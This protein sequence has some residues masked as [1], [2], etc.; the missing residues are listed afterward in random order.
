[1][2]HRIAL[3]RVADPWRDPSSGW[4]QAWT[5]A[6]PARDVTTTYFASDP[7]EL[8][9]SVCAV[10]RRSESSR[11]ILLM[12]RSDNGHWGLPGGYVERGESVLAAAAREVREETGWCVE[13][14]RL[15]GV[16]SDPARQVIEYPDRRRVQAIN[17]CFEALAREAG[18]VGTPGEVTGVG[19]FA[20]DALPE[21]F[22]PIHGIRIEDCF[23]GDGAARVR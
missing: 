9:L 16:Y 18:P 20:V 21:P 6:V 10:V 12:R 14:G 22:V 1:M 5:R 11:E 2:R 13:V 7:T 15:V 19:F 8:R 17:L 3:P 23:A 4:P